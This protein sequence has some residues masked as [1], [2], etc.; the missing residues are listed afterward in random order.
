MVRRCAKGG[1]GGEGHV[2]AAGVVEVEPLV[3]AGCGSV[4]VGFA[5][6]PRSSKL[7]LELNIV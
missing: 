2:G 3:G 6:F 4:E 5:H 1:T 7:V